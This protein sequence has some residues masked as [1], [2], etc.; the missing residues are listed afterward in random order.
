MILELIVFHN[1][2]FLIFHKIF[3]GTRIQWDQRK[4]Y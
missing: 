3:S 2:K 4:I 1:D